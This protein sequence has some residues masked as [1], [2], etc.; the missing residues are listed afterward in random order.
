[1]KSV[2]H[3][4][5]I[6][7][8]F[9]ADQYSAIVLQRLAYQ[10]KLAAVVAPAGAERIKSAAKNLGFRLI[11]WEKPPATS[12]KEIK[13]IK[14]DLGIVASFGY[15][16]PAELIKIP[17]FG[18]LNIHPSLL[19]LYRGP[20]PVPSAIISGEKITGATIIK[21]DEE[22]DH[23]PIIAQVKEAIRPDD[24]STTLLKRLFSLGAEILNA[25]LPAYL[26]NRIEPRPQE[27]SLATYTR[28]LTRKDGFIPPQELLAAIEGK[29]N[30]EKIERMIR[31]L[32]PWPGAWTLINLRGKN[33]EK[34]SRKRL[35]ILKA[36]LEIPQNQQTKTEKDQNGRS[37]KALALDTVQLEGKK[38]VS[39][40]QFKEGYPDSFFGNQAVGDRSLPNQ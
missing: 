22:F 20:T 38:P 17:R 8:F 37:K 31:A 4:K 23:G 11:E 6:I 25:I 39:W 14:P 5:P 26:D 36:H 34:E 21:I 15:L 16:I 33:L 29:S 3:R 9:G 13:D 19:P 32:Y 10:W 24:D 2:N 18:I 1:M 7:I 40:K 35:K 28:R 27:H 12:I 30:P